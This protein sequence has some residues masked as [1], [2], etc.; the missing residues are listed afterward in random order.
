MLFGETG[1]V[2]CENHTEHTDTVHTSQE[3]HYI[4]ATK[5]R[6]LMLFG[7]TDA[8]YCDN[9]AED[10]DIV[11]G[12]NAEFSMLQRAVCNSNRWALKF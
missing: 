10:T 1:R 4:F 6:I 8:V 7:E 12:Q 3:T 11:C 5:P 2:Y 9:H